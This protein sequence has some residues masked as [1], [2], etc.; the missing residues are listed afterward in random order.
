MSSAAW[1]CV[2]GNVGAGI[3]INVVMSWLPTYYEEFILV[4][5]EDISSGALVR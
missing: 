4:E 2:A 1:A 3:A 5:L